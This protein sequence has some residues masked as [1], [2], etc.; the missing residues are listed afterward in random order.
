MTFS[1]I[2]QR[3]FRQKQTSEE[4]RKRKTAAAA[5]MREYCVRKKN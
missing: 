2:L 3:E 1:A 4:V 5:Y